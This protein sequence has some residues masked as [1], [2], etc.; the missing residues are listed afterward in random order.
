MAVVVTPNVGTL[1]FLN[2]EISFTVTMTG[3][4]TATEDKFLSYWLEN[5]AGVKVTPE[6]NYTP[7]EGVAFKI[8][9][10][11]DVFS[12]L[13]TPP[14]TVSPGFGFI[15]LEEEMLK[16]F[17]FVY[18]EITINKLTCVRT[19]TSPVKGSLF[20]VINASPT[21]FDG[22]QEADFI[23]LGKNPR[24]KNT[25]KNISELIYVYST[26]TVDGGVTGYNNKGQWQIGGVSPSQY[27][28]N[29]NGKVG[30]F[31]LMP[32]N[33]NSDIE[34]LSISVRAFEEEGADKNHVFTLNLRDCCDLVEV[35]FQNHRGGYNTFAGRIDK[36]STET[37]ETEVAVVNSDSIHTQLSIA[38]KKAYV[39]Y[40]IIFDAVITKPEDEYFLQSFEASG[41]YYIKLKNRAGTYQQYKAILNSLDRDSINGRITTTF[42]V[43]KDIKQ[44]NYFN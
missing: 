27:E 31:N 28:G 1:N 8:H 7:K 14:P 2:T 38:N 37:S 43:N 13:F 3:V 15:R 21:Y 10:Q 22:I 19:E 18:K 41:K 5:S 20:K 11:D 17:R 12:A 23:I 33:I 39:L 24:V 25:C 35:T 26:G 44:P 9:F 29:L 42:K 30:S 36:I 40:S 34:Y 16:E 4:S 6:L 32:T